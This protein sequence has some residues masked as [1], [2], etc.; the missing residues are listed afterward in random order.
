[1]AVDTSSDKFSVTELRAPLTG[2]MTAEHRQSL[3]AAIGAP[4]DNMAQPLEAWL[5]KRVE[6]TKNRHLSDAGKAESLRQ[7]RETTLQQFDK[8]YKEYEAA[9]LRPLGP[10]LNAAHA[11]VAR[12]QDAPPVMMSATSEDKF[13]IRTQQQHEANTLARIRL[14][15]GE[16]ADVTEFTDVVEKFDEAEV[17]GG[18]MMRRVGK[19]ALLVGARMVAASR[20]AG[21]GAAVDSVDGR[22]L[23]DMR[24]RYAAWLKENPTPGRQLRQA[25]D[26]HAIRKG[27]LAR[28]KE[29]TLKAY[30]FS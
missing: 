22:R 16:L 8:A 6:I 21:V 11:A 15:I 23:A 10:A 27:E 29:L 17:I 1:M 9:E 5:Q 25:Q 26:S 18:E 30:G 28:Q 20:T 24:T 13:R 12:L 4:A 7:L 14:D 19:K 2:P 3:F